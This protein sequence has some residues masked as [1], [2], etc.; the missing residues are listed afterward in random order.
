M[1]RAKKKKKI[2]RRKT[3]NRRRDCKRICL[4]SDIEIEDIMIEIQRKN[5][6]ETK[7]VNPIRH[8]GRLS[9]IKEEYPNT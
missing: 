7:D 2:K 9:K 5:L 8:V 4:I 6:N 1:L 3:N